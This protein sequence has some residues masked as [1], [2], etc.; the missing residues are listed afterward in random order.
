MKN[1]Y[2]VKNHCKLELPNI[3]R[4]FE[5]S[6]WDNCQDGLAEGISVWEP[7]NEYGFKFWHMAMWLLG[8]HLT[9]LASN[10]EFENQES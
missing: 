1:Y 4:I 7:E 6:E 2:M 5:Y 10:S 9:S 3:Y 8:S